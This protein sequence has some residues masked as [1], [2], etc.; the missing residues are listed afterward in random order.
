MS[1]E[2]E[3]FAQ[4]QLQQNRLLPFG[5]TQD[6]QGYH[7]TREILDGEFIATVTVTAKGEVTGRVCDADF[8]EEYAPMRVEE[9]QGNYVDAVR[10]AYRE[11]L[12]EIRTACF[13]SEEEAKRNRAPIAWVLPS[14]PKHFDVLRGFAENGDVLNWH[15]RADIHVG[16]TVYIYVG[17]P[18]SA[19]RFRCEA[20]AVNLSPTEE[21]PR[22]NMD[23]RRLETYADDQ[24]P[25]SFLMANGLNNIRGLRTIPMTLHEIIL[26]GSKNV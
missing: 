5:F 16:D 24:W 9:A 26:Q 21:E 14:N 1:I 17:A 6:A 10:Y 2:S 13:I 7:Y 8:G 18:I 23:I 4:Y 22:K 20:I 3:I 11:L 25:R 19:I 12:E 15:Q